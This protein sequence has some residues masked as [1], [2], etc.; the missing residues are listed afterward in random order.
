M[1]PEV[2]LTE[3]QQARIRSEELAA[4]GELAAGYTELLGEWEVTVALQERGVD[5]AFPLGILYL[6]AMDEYCATHW[7]KVGEPALAQ[8]V[9]VIPPKL[10]RSLAKAELPGERRRAWLRSR[11]AGNGHAAPPKANS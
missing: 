8:S 4:S 3:Y 9:E 7:A 6:V 11:R 5:W 2:H 1:I 10:M